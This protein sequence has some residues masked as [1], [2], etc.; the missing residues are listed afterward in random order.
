MS[1]GCSARYRITGSLS[2]RFGGTSPST[3]DPATAGACVRAQRPRARIL[4]SARACSR[5][6][7]TH[8]PRAHHADLC[9]AGRT[10][11]AAVAVALAAAGGRGHAHVSAQSEQARQRG[12]RRTARGGWSGH[13]ATYQR[14]M[15]RPPAR[16]SRARRGVEC[17]RHGPVFFFDTNLG[18]TCSWCALLISA[19][20]HR[21]RSCRPE[22]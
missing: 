5:R 4:S 15:S 17:R 12:A 21:G 3:D 2:T 20:T 14:S 16:L 19:T 11:V 22:V 13:D 10:L 18:Y 7:R 8:T 6:A 9:G 1:G